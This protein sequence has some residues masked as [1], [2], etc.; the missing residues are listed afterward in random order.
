MRKG[1]V[2]LFDWASVQVPRLSW[3]DARWLADEGRIH[4]LELPHWR[5]ARLAYYV[6]IDMALA[7][8]IGLIPAIRL[9]GWKQRP[10]PQP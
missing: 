8:R 7:Q 4:T 2:Q 10:T 5:K 1:A 3:W 9:S 6:P